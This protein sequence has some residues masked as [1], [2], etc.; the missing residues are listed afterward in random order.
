MDLENRWA[1]EEF[2]GAELGDVRRRSRLIA[3]GAQAAK[4]PGGRV[5]EVFPTDATRQGAYD[6]LESAYVRPDRVVDAI[7][8]ACVERCRDEPYVFV[9]VD[10][11]SLNLTDRALC[12]GFGRI[13][14]DSCH[15]RGLKVIDAIAVSPQ[16]VPLGICALQWW[17]RGRKCPKV[18]CEVELKETQRWLDAIQITCDQFASRS[19][20]IRLWFQLDREADCWPI[21]QQ[22][23]SSGQSF[24]VRSRTNRRLHHAAGKKLFLRQHLKRQTAL[25]HDVLQ[26]PTSARRTGRQAQL[27]IRAASVTLDMRDKRTKKHRLLTLNAV[28]VREVATTPRGEKPLDWLLL[29]SEPVAT[30]EQARLVIFG[31]T[32]RWRIEDFHRSWKSGAC[33]VENTQLRAKEHVIRWATLLSAVALRIERLKHISRSEPDLPAS[34][35]LT[36]HEIEALV[37]LKRIDKKRNETIPDVMPT[38]AQATLWI[39]EL[40]GYTGKSSGGPPG[41]ITIRRGLDRLRPAAKLLKALQLPGKLR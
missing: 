23:G 20:S 26:L 8:G 41:S 34:V 28:W 30:L 36:R 17:A 32:Q 1:Y 21:L 7:A 13:G 24:T 10:G 6:F 14:A 12:K 15:A 9:P 11:T 16:G 31:Y 22:L 5:S 18:S 2:G 29:T 35:E 39:A 27:L 25:G 4:V 37:H 19:T 3:M 40:G 33:N 38:I